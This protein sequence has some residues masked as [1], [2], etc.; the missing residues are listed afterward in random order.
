MY[1]IPTH[2]M[3]PP[4]IPT[5]DIDEPRI[6]LLI[7]LRCDSR[8]GGSLNTVVL[9]SNLVNMC[10]YRYDIGLTLVSTRLYIE[11]RGK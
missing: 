9:D 11:R 8:L 1:N 7:D 3:R 6:D 4:S 2:R 10:I 5:P